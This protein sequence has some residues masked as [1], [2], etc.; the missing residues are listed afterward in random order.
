MADPL[1]YFPPDQAG[2]EHSSLPFCFRALD[3]TP[4]TSEHATGWERRSPDRRFFG[5]C[6]LACVGARVT[7]RPS[8]SIRPERVFLAVSGALSREFVAPDPLRADSVSAVALA[9]R[10]RCDRLT[11]LLLAVAFGAGF[12]AC[13]EGESPSTPSAPSAGSPPHVQWAIEDR[14]QDG[15]ST[16]WRLFQ[17]RSERIVKIWP[18]S[19]RV[20]TAVAGGGAT[21]VTVI[22]DQ[23]ERG[24]QICMGAE[25]GSRYWGVGLHGIRDC[26]TCCE[27]VPRGGMVTRSTDLVC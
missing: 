14:C 13:T 26:S 7:A 15:H 20:Y 10:S 8:R 2:S 12:T 22:P 5:I 17:F 21:T 19:S 1:A 18:S 3:A 16:E 27:D 25:A 9:P 24:G 23:P 11:V 4:F 6:L